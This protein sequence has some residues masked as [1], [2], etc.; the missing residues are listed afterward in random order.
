MSRAAIKEMGTMHVIWR[1]TVCGA[2]LFFR[3]IG[4]FFFNYVLI[5]VYIF[6]IYWKKKKKLYYTDIINMLIVERRERR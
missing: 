1:H 2:I 5:F 4:D 6:I 3:C